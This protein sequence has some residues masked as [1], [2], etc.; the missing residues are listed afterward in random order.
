MFAALALRAD[1]PVTVDFLID[2]TWAARPPRTCREQVHNCVVRLRRLLHTMSGGGCLHRTGD[3]YRLEVDPARV[4]AHAFVGEVYRSRRLAVTGDLAGAVA[5]TRVGL[6]HWYGD[7]LDGIVDGVLGAEAARL[8]EMRLSAYEDLFTH[9]LDLGHESTVVTEVAALARRHPLRERLVLLLMTS[10]ARTGRSAEALRVYREHRRRLV[11]ELGVE[12][13][14][15]LRDLEVDILREA[16]ATR[17]VSPAA[18]AE[19]AALL[20]ELARLAEEV[21]RRLAS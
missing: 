19:L 5:A 16:G 4:D 2:A 17:T 3:G 21:A 10:L 9:E 11:D 13:D 1:H 20:T 6:G 18:P 8:D 15:A 12:P 7:A 14:R